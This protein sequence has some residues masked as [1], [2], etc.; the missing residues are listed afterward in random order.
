[1]SS[2]PS[3]SAPRKAHTKQPEVG[4]LPDTH[5][6]FWAEREKST[7]YNVFMDFQR[8]TRSQMNI[9]SNLLEK[10]KAKDVELEE[11]CDL[12]K[13]NTLSAKKKIETVQNEM[14]SLFPRVGLLEQEKNRMSKTVN[15]LNQESQQLSFRID[16]IEHE[17]HGT[18]TPQE[19]YEQQPDI[20]NDPGPP[21]PRPDNFRDPRQYRR[22]EDEDDVSYTTQSRARY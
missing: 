8:E 7:P 16:D 21:P 6:E 5:L 9:F 11:F 3:R 13:S 2:M 17:L 18:P 14:D 12:L 10:L 22:Y 1:M 4:V 19:A 20:Y 15:E